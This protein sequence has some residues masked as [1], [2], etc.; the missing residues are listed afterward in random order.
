M[1]L[2]GTLSVH[3]VPV[4]YEVERVC[5]PI[6][7]NDGDHAV[8][9]RHEDQSENGEKCMRLVTEKLSDNGIE[10][11]IRDTHFFELYDCLGEMR[12][13][14]D[15]YEEED[16]F[17]NISTGSKITAV[18]GMMAC[19]ATGTQPYYVRA[20]GYSAEVI[21]EGRGEI[22]PLSAYPVGLPDKQYLKVL[23]FLS[24]E[25]AVYKKDVIEYVKEEDL[26]L[27]SGYSR[28]QLKNQYE[29]VNKEIIEPLK[30]RGFVETQRYGQGKKVKLTE[31][32]ETT[33]QGL[34]YLLD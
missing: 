10:Y 15:E 16:I 31:E 27:L 3:L 14:I 9:F 8:L 12:T 24:S 7:E 11:D 2:Q 4:G 34:Q 33:L 21:T 17:V 22:I 18:A 28:Q 6:I 20:E 5:D 13:Q 26:P 25:D 19:M 23:E 1:I 32:G 29:P 30:E